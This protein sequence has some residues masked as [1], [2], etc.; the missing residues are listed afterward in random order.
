MQVATVLHGRKIRLS[1]RS[2]E[3][4]RHKN[5]CLSCSYT[6]LQENMVWMGRTYHVCE[7]FCVCERE[8]AIGKSLSDEVPRRV[9]CRWHEY[10]H[11]IHPMRNK[12]GYIEFNWYI[13][14]S[15]CE[16]MIWKGN[17]YPDTKW[18]QLSALISAVRICKVH[19]FTVSSWLGL[20]L[21]F[22]ILFHN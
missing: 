1:G 17:L 14:H 13:I 19:F 20:S 11:F 9:S 3:P 16:W 6:I 12:P 18:N 15:Y 7:S 8:K 5:S 22:Y 10:S 2:Q 4:C 21:C